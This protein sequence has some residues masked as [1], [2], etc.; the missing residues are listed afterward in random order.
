MLPIPIQT[1]Q[2][3]SAEWLA[4]PKVAQYARAEL[5]VGLAGS[6]TN[7]FDPAQAALDARI[8]TPSGRVLT[9][10]GFFYRAYS[11][12]AG[13]TTRTIAVST[14]QAAAEGKAALTETSD[15]GEILEPTGPAEWR[16]R[17]APQEK[18]VHKVELVWRTPSGTAN[19]KVEN[20]TAAPGKGGFVRMSKF[21]PRYFALDDGSSYWP[22]G[23]NLGWAGARGTRDYDDWIPAFT[24]GGANWGRMWLA[25]QWT[26]LALERET[27]QPI[28]LA[29][30]W[31]LD[32][33]LGLAEEHGMRLALCIESYNI[34]RE[35]DNWPEWERSPINRAN[36]G[37]LEKPGDFWTDPEADRRFRNKLRY[38][39]ARYGAST[40]V[41][42][43]ELWNEV[44]GVT[45]YQPERVRAWHDR[46]ATALKAMDPYRHLI[47]TSFGGHGMAAGD[48]E[49]FKLKSLDY[50]QTHSYEAPDI[51][52]AVDEANRR[53]G[54]LG[55]PHFIGEIG[56]DTTGPRAEE[57]PE[58]WQIHD[59]IW[60][61][62]AVGES[63]A[64]MPWW[65][66]SY[67]SPKGLYG[68]FR[69]VSDFVKGV[70][71]DREGFRRVTPTFA[72]Q[73]PPKETAKRDIVF[74][75]NF[76]GWT[77]SFQNVPRTI[78][79][80]RNGADDLRPL[81]ALQQGVGNHADLHNPV[82]FEIDLP[83]PTRVVAEVGDV[84]GYGGAKLVARLD[85]REVLNK[86]FADPDGDRVTATLKQ[87]AGDYGVDVPAGKHRVEFENPGQDWFNV[88][89]RVVGAKEQ[90]APPLLGWAV[91]GKTTALAWVRQEERTWK[92]VTV[93]KRTF[94][95]SP[96][97]IL[98]LPGLIGNWKAE[99]W[100]TRTGKMVGQPPVLNGRLPLPEIATD[101]AVKLQKRS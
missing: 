75:A 58:G 25:P 40:S 16:V 45:D 22:L 93:Q 101:L 6:V 67:V 42:S 2:I 70:A 37:P 10:P 60:A 5:R 41:M 46:M 43:W 9:V 79:I 84:S 28:D 97:S 64:T 56:A 20:L 88:T 11:R 63:G 4:G 33:V 1:V 72:Y 48:A 86:D 50:A 57:D 62:V 35:G 95:V 92:A 59:P 21:D 18:G 98:N 74:T 85:G 31:R 68:L 90:T 54:N 61:S 49:A 76:P 14:T 73:T 27:G 32:Y 82:T 65:W 44:D 96:P 94:P 52:V 100:D 77:P 51:A 83:W 71:F 13:K 7:P 26:T 15:D 36:G 8:T 24:K 34:L 55:K 38:L 78:K 39:V 80:G 12:R 23:A 19:R 87:F 29:N 66:D 99:L 53:L 89:F 47:T 17:F 30:A 91:V 3:Q 69:P 81:S